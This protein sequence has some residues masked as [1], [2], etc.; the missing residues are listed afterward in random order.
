MK[1]PPEE[2]TLE[3]YDPTGAIEVTQ[4]HAPRL[5]D[6][7]GKTVG[8]ISNGWWEADRTFPLIRELL[9]KQFPTLKIIPYTE[10]PTLS[11]TVDIPGLEAAVKAKGV[12]A[13]IVGN[14]A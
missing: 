6:L 4:A 8:E 10:F 11:H 9:Q 13:A 7:N 12:Q 14:A 5:P 2:V 3:L 1:Q